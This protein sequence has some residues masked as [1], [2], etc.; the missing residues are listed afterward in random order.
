MRRAAH[1]S[2]RMLTLVIVTGCL[3]LPT[4]ACSVYMAASQPDKKNLS[5]LESTG[6]HRDT[7]VAQ[8]GAPTSSTEHPDGTRTDVYEFYEGSAT[9]WKV[10]RATFHAVADVFTLGLWE[11]IG[12]PTEMVIKGDKRIARARYDRNSILTEF[13]V[14]GAEKPEQSDEAKELTKMDE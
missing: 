9:G 2:G 1:D 6:M 3:L 7:V 13:E 4:S 5:A 11:I 10:G 14:L 8:L 12:T